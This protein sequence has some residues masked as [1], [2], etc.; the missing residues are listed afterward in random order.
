MCVALVELQKANNANLTAGHAI[1]QSF[2]GY[3]GIE[4]YQ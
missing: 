2:M 1:V 3:R 4:E